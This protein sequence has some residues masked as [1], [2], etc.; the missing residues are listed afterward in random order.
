VLVKYLLQI[1]GDERAADSAPQDDMAHEYGRLADEMRAAGVFLSG[2]GLQPTI[3]ATSVRVRDGEA[4]VTDGPF[5]ETK[6]QLG[7]YFVI[8]CED[9]DRAIEWAARLP[10]A[11][12]GTIEVRPVAEYEEPRS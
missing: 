8:D 11:R 6:E 12:D 2:E 10:G 3:T 1:W 7:G 5:A 4:A 9:L